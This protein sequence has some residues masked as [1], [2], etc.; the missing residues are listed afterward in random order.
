[1]P[2]VI[3]ADHE[4]DH[5]P[6]VLERRVPVLPGDDVGTLHERIKA[7]ERRLYPR[8]I[9]EFVEGATT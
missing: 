8:T 3:I 4:Y 7:T 9:R 1:M 6:S 5:G 2:L